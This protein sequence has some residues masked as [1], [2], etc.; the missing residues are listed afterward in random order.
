MGAL[1]L[2]TKLPSLGFDVDS[3]KVS[4][5]GAFS[6]TEFYSKSDSAG[7]AAPYGQHLVLSREKL[8]SHPDKGDLIFAGY[9]SN[10]SYEWNQENN[11]SIVCKSGGNPQIMAHSTMV[12]GVK[13]DLQIVVEKPHNKSLKNGTPESGAP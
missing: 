7:H 6:I 4:P 5:N 8:I 12:Y 3:N 10:L 9:C 11:I 1:S 2:N 13:I